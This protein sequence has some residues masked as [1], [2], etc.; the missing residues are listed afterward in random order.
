MRDSRLRFERVRELC[1]VGIV[2]GAAAGLHACSSDSTLKVDILPLPESP[3]APPP[4]DPIASGQA[5]QLWLSLSDFSTGARTLLTY[6]DGRVERVQVANEDQ[7]ALVAVWRDLRVLME[8]TS[9]DVSFFMA[10]EVEVPAATVRAVSDEDVTLNPSVFVELSPSEALLF[11]RGAN[12]VWL[13][14]RSGDSVTRVGRA[15]IDSLAAPADPSG[16]VDVEAA[17]LADARVLVAMGRYAFNFDTFSL[18]FFGSQLAAFDVEALRQAALS[19]AEAV[20]TTLVD[21][22]WENP[23]AGLAADP[24]NGVLWVGSG[25]TYGALDGGI[26]ALDLTTLAALPER[27]CSEEALDVDLGQIAML[28]DLILSPGVS[29]GRGELVVRS[30]GLTGAEPL[31]LLEAEC[32]VRALPELGIG[33][34]GMVATQQPASFITWSP[35]NLRFRTGGLAFTLGTAALGLPV[36]SAAQAGLPNARP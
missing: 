7:D 34:A 26:Q 16:L 21:L 17:L 3:D 24:A 27:S 9:G 1:V 18:D 28:P 19:G 13:L 31:Y 32:S 23:V 29:G 6:R 2:C 30:S 20:P 22:A 5:R 36:Y 35:E 14:E 4:E 25:A 10:D 33:V 8:R 11:M 15:S 12:E